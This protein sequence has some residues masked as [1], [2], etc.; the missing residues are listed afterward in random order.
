MTKQKQ[1]TR[2]AA[3]KKAV[4]KDPV[5]PAPEKKARKPKKP[6]PILVSEEQ[7]LAMRTALAAQALQNA[8][9][10]EKTEE[11]GEYWQDIHTRMVRVATFGK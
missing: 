2:A 11:G 4:K 9:S 5:K 10:W 8:F 7:A 6:V 3:A 1:K